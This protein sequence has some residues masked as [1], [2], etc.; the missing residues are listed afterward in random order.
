MISAAKAVLALAS[1]ASAAAPD[2]SPPLQPPT[3]APIT[4]ALV[5]E[6]LA[7]VD[8]GLKTLTSDFEQAVKWDESGTRQTVTGRMEYK[9]K[10]RLRVEHILPEEQTI[11]AD[12]AWLWVHRESTN[13]VIRTKLED[14]KKTEPLAQ[15]L[16]DLGQYATMQEKYDVKIATVT[17]DGEHKKIAL[18]LRPKDDP[19]RFTLTLRLSTKDYFPADTELRVGGVVI[20]SLFKKIRYNP[21]I[22]DARFKFTPPPGADVFQK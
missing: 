20:R 6:R 21:K 3:T 12:G 2:F 15:G 10:D 16:L 5:A 18:E 14:W 1:L 11:V 13:Q 7:A 4:V 22:D 9:K 19:K 17:P 8:A